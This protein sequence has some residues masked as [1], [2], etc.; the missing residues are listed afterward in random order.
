[1]IGAFHNPDT[2]CIWHE[3]LK[4]FHINLSDNEL[5]FRRPLGCA[6]FIERRL[7][8]NRQTDFVRFYTALVEYEER[9]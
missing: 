4:I 2:W 5:G 7:M 6:E 1:M 3:S 9:K 8:E